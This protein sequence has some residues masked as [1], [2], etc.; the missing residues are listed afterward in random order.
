[1]TRSIRY[2]AL[3]RI[4]LGACHAAAKR[5]ILTISSLRFCAAKRVKFICCACG[6]VVS[7]NLFTF[8]HERPSDREGRSAG[9]GAYMKYVSIPS[10]ARP[11]ITRAQEDREQV[12]SAILHRF[13]LAFH[14][15]MQSIDSAQLQNS[16]ADRGLDKNGEIAP[17]SDL[18]RDAAHRNAQHILRLLSQ[19][20][21]LEFLIG[22]AH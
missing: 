11:C 12:L 1:M 13:S 8:C 15:I 2:A 10:T 19:R 16:V 6:A 14:K 18:Q 22:A 7:K 17:G 20:Q 21:A 9:S 4:A 5:C 3:L